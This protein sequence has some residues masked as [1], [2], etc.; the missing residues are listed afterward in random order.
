MTAVRTHTRFGTRGSALA[1]WQTQ[2]VMSL[3]QTVRPSLI[4]D[5]EVISTRGDQIVDTPLPLIGGKGLF[6][7][8]LE[9][10]LYREQ[11]DAAVHSLKDLPTEQPDGL[12]IAA[13]IERANAADVLISRA[14]CTLA[15]LPPG[16]RVGTCSRR[17]AAQLLAIRPDL[18]LLDL[19]GNVDTRIRKAFE[20]DGPYD[21]IVLAYAGVER[22]NRL[23][24]VSQI[25]EY[26][27]M[28]PAPGQGAIA[29]QTRHSDDLISLLSPLN[30]AATALA[31]RAERAFLA[32]LGGGCSVPVAAF[33]ELRGSH[34]V[35]RGRVCSLD[36]RHLI[37]VGNFTT[38]LDDEN[39]QQ[40][41]LSLAEQALAEGA[42]IILEHSA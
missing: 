32:G 33:A 14:G 8:A 13:I 24:A 6:T 40:L 3:L 22:L 28:L 16:A 42:R 37:D 18:T 39:A 20:S 36:G 19:R 4:I 23:D 31:V 11:I 27:D 12:T 34:L 38:S 17:R 10:A 9:A 25:L 21:A 15:T 30:H 5:H 35:L 26:D 29:V 1:M 2:H 7:E 41:G